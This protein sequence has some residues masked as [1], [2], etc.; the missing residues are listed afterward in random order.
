MHELFEGGVAD[1][2]FVGHHRQ[3]VGVFTRPCDRQGDAEVGRAHVQ[4]ATQAGGFEREH[5]LAGQGDVP[6]DLRALGQRLGGGARG[7]AHGVE[8]AIR[9]LET[10]FGQRV[11]VVEVALEQ[12]RAGVHRLA[13]TQ[14]C[15]VE[16]R[17]DVTLGLGARDRHVEAAFAPALAE[18]AEPRRHV[19]LARASLALAMHRGVPEREHDHV[20]LVPLHRLQVLHERALVE[21][22][23]GAGRLPQPRKRFVLVQPCFD[24]VED[25]LALFEVEGHHPDAGWFGTRQQLGEQI[26]HPCS[27]DVVHS[28]VVRAV[29]HR[30]PAQ[31]GLPMR[32]R[33]RGDREQVPLV[34]RVVGKRDQLLFAT[35]VVPLE[36]R[37]RAAV[38]REREQ[39]FGGEHVAHLRL[40]FGEVV[41]FGATARG[42]E[43]RRGRH[44]LF[45]ARHDHLLGAQEHR[46]PR[47]HG[48]L[49]R[50][51]ED[52]QVEQRCAGKQH[53]HRLG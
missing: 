16:R 25:R 48:A 44:L 10:V 7:A 38:A 5:D 14:Q 26:D 27:L 50:L 3:G 40:L 4:R 24:L 47:L 51:V 46:K 20:A 13:D 30:N 28:A 17:D 37:V 32:P 52:D 8:N 23:V 45:V 31:R 18:R 36:A 6:I 42:L 2:T 39:R 12:S 15:R 22:I 19:E 11:G 33:G 49:R 9:D 29:V 21:L 35:A 41:F 43:V 1:R 34:H 53:R